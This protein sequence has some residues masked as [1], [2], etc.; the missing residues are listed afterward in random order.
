MFFELSPVIL[1]I[2]VVVLII[3]FFLPHEGNASWLHWIVDDDRS[4]FDSDGCG[5]TGD[6][7]G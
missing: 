7:F 6:F 1:A 3:S 5:F 4:D 2:I